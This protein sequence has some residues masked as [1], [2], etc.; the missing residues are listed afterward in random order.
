MLKHTMPKHL[1]LKHTMLKRRW[2]VI[3]HY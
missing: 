3:T 2:I 1:I